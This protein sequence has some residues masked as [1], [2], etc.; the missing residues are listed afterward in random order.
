MMGWFFFGVSVG[1]VIGIIVNSYFGGDDISYILKRM[2]AK[3]NGSINI[4]DFRIIPKEK[5]ERRKLFNF[6]K[7]SKK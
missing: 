6:K 2:R 3:K 5:K 1:I 7:R 4:S